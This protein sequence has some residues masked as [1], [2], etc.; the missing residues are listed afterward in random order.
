MIYVLFIY[1][2]YAAEVF[3]FIKLVGTHSP[4]SKLIID[5]LLHVTHSAHGYFHTSKGHRV[6]MT[7][8][9]N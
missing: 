8:L 5:H 9:V 6:P 2:R 1:L 3:F 7:A 4:Y